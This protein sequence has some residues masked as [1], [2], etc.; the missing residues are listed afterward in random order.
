MKREK[1]IKTNTNI[2]RFIVVRSQHLLLRSLPKPHLGVY[3]NPTDY[4]RLFYKLT[5]QLVVFTSAQRT[6]SV[7]PGSPTR[8]NPDCFPGLTIKPLHVGFTLGSPT[9][10]SPLVF[11]FGSPTNLSP[12]VFPLAHQQTLHRWFSLWLTNK[13]LT[14]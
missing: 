8:T 9:N 12:L 14:P 5:T 1:E 13:P 11:P 6:R 7:F 10:L 2:A 4:S 3:Y